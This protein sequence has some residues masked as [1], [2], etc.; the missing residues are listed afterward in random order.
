MRERWLWAGALV[1]LVTCTTGCEE[2][3]DPA[4]PSQLGQF[5][6][7]SFEYDCDTPGDPVCDDQCEDA[8]NAELCEGLTFDKT[9]IPTLA[10][11]SSFLLGADDTS[12]D[13][14]SSSDDRLS[15]M[16]GAWV[17]HR[18]G[19]T[20]ILA[21]ASDGTVKDLVDVRVMDVENIDLNFRATYDATA[22]TFV[23]TARL[24]LLG[25]DD[26]PLGGAF[27]CEWTSSDEDVVALTSDTT[28]NA[29]SFEFGTP[30]TATLTATLGPHSGSLM[31]EVTP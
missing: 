28:D 12:V 5:G 24:V 14:V 31:I 18:T 3:E 25:M 10:V 29:V 9:T 21:Q 4:P 8:D 11:G 1:A 23:G 2:E 16:D 22:D 19:I 7:V 27:P 20:S 30:G 15:L 13:I 26:E 6:A 17:T